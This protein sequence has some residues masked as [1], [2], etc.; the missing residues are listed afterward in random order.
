MIDARVLLD[1]GRPDGAVY[2]AGYA[3]ECAWKHALAGAFGQAGV[4]ALEHGLERGTVGRAAWAAAASGDRDLLRVQL[5][6]REVRDG[7][8]GR[9]YWPDRWSAEQAETVV[10]F[11]EVAVE[12]CVL[13][14]ALDR[15]LDLKELR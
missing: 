14:P 6:P 1:A 10:V 5:A 15:G 12:R 8:P 7:H 9:R 4:R 13:G 11:A 3:V 2:L